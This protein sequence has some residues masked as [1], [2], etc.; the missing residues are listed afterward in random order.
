MS[1]KAIQIAAYSKE[2]G[3]EYEH[4]H[5]KKKKKKNNNKNYRNNSPAVTTHN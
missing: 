3:M 1:D 4:R 2:K 5:V